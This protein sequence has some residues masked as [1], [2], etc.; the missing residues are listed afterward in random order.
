MMC[1]INIYQYTVYT[2][3]YIYIQQ[4]VLSIRGGGI[5]VNGKKRIRKLFSPPWGEYCVLSWSCQ[6]SIMQ[7]WWVYS[8]KGKRRGSMVLYIHTQLICIHTYS[9]ILKYIM[10]MKVMKIPWFQ[11][12]VCLK[13]EQFSK[14]KI[15]FL[16]LRAFKGNHYLLTFLKLFCGETRCKGFRKHFCHL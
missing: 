7:V 9:H 2:V 12:L 1:Q 14:I 16:T 6:Y 10:K 5:F 13:R 11:Q 4:L 8:S 15:K 3:Q